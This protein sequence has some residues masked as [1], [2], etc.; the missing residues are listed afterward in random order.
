M[1]KQ[2]HFFIFLCLSFLFFACG[3]SNSASS[4][5]S[6]KAIISLDSI[7]GYSQK[8][9]FLK[10]SDIL[11]YELQDGKT[12]KQTGASFAGKITNDNGRFQIKARDIQSQ[13]VYLQATGYFRNEFTSKNSEGILS[14]EAITD[15]NKHKQVNVN[16]LTHLEYHRVLYLVTKKG[17]NFDEAK[18]RAQ[19]DIFKTFDIDTTL[20]ENLDVSPENLSIGGNTE[21]DAAL[22]AISVLMMGSFEDCVKG[23]KEQSDQ[24]PALLTDLLTSISTDLETDGKWDS[25]PQKNEYLYW[26]MHE[27]INGDAPDRFSNIRKNIMKWYSI[28]SVPNFEKYIVNF[29]EKE[30]GLGHCDSTN[31][32]KV[33]E[34]VLDPEYKQVLLEKNENFKFKCIQQYIQVFN[35]K[36]HSF[37]GQDSATGWWY[38]KQL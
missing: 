27:T 38:W 19:Q 7:I 18:K 16:L 9:P 20:F 12:L 15:V 14:L 11:L 35:E 13:Y 4:A 6:E 8:G 3:D 21:A 2:I 37:T 1:K 22:I 31:E 17:M 5:E 23:Y 29:Y 10:G 33:K 28:D 26:L 34:I 32:G 36:D 24:C 25:S 30:S